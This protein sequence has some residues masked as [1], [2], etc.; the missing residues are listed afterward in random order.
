M[1]ILGKNKILPL[2]AVSGMNITNPLAFELTTLPYNI[3]LLV[4]S[5]NLEKKLT[6]LSE[7]MPEIVAMKS[8]INK[9]DLRFEDRI[10]VQKK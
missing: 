6:Q 5:S 8:R 10:I 3:P 7:I 4:T 9:I 1:S 2:S